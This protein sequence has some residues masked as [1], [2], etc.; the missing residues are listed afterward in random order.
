[1]NQE[2]P[3]KMRKRK[4]TQP[5]EELIYPS[6]PDL[7]R[8]KRQEQALKAEAERNA[9]TQQ[10]SSSALLLPKPSGLSTSTSCSTTSSY[11]QTPSC[12]LPSKQPQQPN[13][14]IRYLLIHQVLL[15]PQ[16]SYRRFLRY[17]NALTC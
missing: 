6:M 4:V 7:L 13:Y 3:M 2:T 5:Y 12:I 1:M 10:T 8:V 16:D 14:A 17:S 9:A 15:I 11:S